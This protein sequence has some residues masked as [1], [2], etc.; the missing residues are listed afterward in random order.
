MSFVTDGNMLSGYIDSSDNMPTFNGLSSVSDAFYEKIKH[1]LF[2]N[3]FH[4][5]FPGSP[6]LLHLGTVL[7]SDSY[8]NH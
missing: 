5:P 6:L 1:I 3:A 4:V 2:H 7:P 8:L